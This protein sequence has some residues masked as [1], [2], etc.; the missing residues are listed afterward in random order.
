MGRTREYRMRVDELEPGRVVT[1]SDTGSS[2]ARRPRSPR[3]T[4]RRSC[5][6]PRS[7][8]APGDRGVFER[9]FAPRVV[10]AIYTDELKR[11]DAYAREHR[12]A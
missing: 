11:L 4:A 10:G 12:S 6:S 8:T 3:E 5:G 1:E 9:I 2:L 7:G